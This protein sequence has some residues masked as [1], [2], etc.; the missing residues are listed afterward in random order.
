MTEAEWVRLIA[1][2][3]SS[4]GLGELSGLEVRVGEK[5]P[6]GYEIRKY[7]GDGGSATISYETDLLIVETSQDGT[8]KPRVVI[9]A[10]IRTINTHD[11]ITYSQKAASHRSIHPY[12]RYGVM[13]GARGHHPLPGRLY[14]HGQNFDFMVSFVDFE[15]TSVEWTGF[16]QLVQSEV[17]ASRDMERLLYDTRGKDRAHFTRLHRR[18]DLS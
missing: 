15:L 10:K 2:R 6:Y 13:L 8:W 5:L 3:L 11:A 12:L 16:V 14:R 4:D 9:E 17:T 1:A 7:G 18:L